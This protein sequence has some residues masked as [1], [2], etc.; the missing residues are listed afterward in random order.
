MFLFWPNDEAEAEAEPELLGRKSTVV[1]ING[2]IV[3][4]E[5]EEEEDDD[6]TVGD[7]CS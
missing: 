5:E 6:D 1:A 4:D 7:F 2:K 3:C